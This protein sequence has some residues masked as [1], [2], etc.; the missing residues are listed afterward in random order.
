MK[1]PMIPERPSLVQGLPMDRAPAWLASWLDCVDG[2]V[3]TGGSLD[4]LGRQ[5][6]S[7]WALFRAGESVGH[8]TIEIGP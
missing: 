5:I 1:G 6:T 7:S 2:A 3:A 8:I 4:A